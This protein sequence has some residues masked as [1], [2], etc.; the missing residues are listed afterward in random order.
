MHTYTEV[1]EEQRRHLIIDRIDDYVEGEW[2]GV[3]QPI[4]HTDGQLVHSGLHPSVL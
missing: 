2:G 4:T 3:M 1:G